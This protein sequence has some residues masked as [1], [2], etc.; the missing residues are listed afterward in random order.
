MFGAS[1]GPSR[2]GRATRK[3]EAQALGPSHVAELSR[4]R[5]RSS[6][7][8]NPRTPRGKTSSESEMEVEKFVAETRRQ[9]QKNAAAARAQE[10][11]ARRGA[12][13]GKI[14]HGAA[15]VNPVLQGKVEG[16][17]ISD[18]EIN[19]QE[20]KGMEIKTVPLISSEVNIE[21]PVIHVNVHEDKHVSVEKTDFKTMCKVT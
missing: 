16:K 4:P 7:V 20:H 5:L 2:A 18:E 9:K 15:N 1:P 3:T 13:K 6:S 12:P 17:Q 10:V 19:Q 11:E 21:L 14:S 8:G